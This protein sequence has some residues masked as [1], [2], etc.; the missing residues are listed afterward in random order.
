MRSPNLDAPQ[1]FLMMLVRPTNEENW[2][3][4]LEHQGKYGSWFG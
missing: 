3:D 4:I 1:Q 2:S